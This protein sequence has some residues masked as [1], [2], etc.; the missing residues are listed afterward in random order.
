MAEPALR[1]MTVAEFV[2]WDDGTDQR[3]ELVGGVPVAMNPPAAPHAL[4]VTEV[5]AALRR[6]LERPCAAYSG[7]GVRAADDDRTFRVP[8][9]V[10]SCRPSRGAWVEEPRLIVEVLS[11]STEREDATKKLAFHRGIASVE[12]ILLVWSDARR[13]EHWRREGPAWAVRDVIGSGELELR[14]CAE[15]LGLDEI[16]AGLDL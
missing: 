6:R 16:Y 15:S 12:E 4:I 2:A 10:V 14:S 11:P 7:G 1:L 5:G 3:Y 8:D 13:V 9:V